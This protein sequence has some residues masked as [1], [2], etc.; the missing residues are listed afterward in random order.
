MLAL[1]VLATG[2]A[3]AASQL[4]GPPVRSGLVLTG[5]PGAAP[6]ALA[7]VAA[8]DP[9]G[10]PPWGVRV[11]T[12]RWADGR[13][14]RDLTCVQIG[15]VLDG[16]LGVIGEDG[17]FGD[18]GLFHV[19]PVEPAGGC[20]QAAAGYTFVNYVPA[21]GFAGSGSC[22]IPSVLLHPLAAR[23]RRAARNS[24]ACPI[25]DLR[26]VVYGVA[27]RRAT[28]VRLSGA[29]GAVSERL[30]HADRGAFIFVLSAA[31]PAAAHS[32]SVT[33]GY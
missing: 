17:A 32:V 21:S 6:V 22:A 23:I 31:D 27:N 28:R 2:T 30:V 8:D 9:A 26:L 29:F 11:Y 7:A 18:D 5:R 1:L 25:G 14:G 20:D 16:R 33:F 19:L 10:G 12:P 4:F 3:L 13:A 24:R 15:R